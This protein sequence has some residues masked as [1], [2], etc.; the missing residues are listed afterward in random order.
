MPPA[1]AAERS[2]QAALLSKL[3]HEIVIS[4]EFWKHITRLSKNIDDLDKKD[5]N[6]VSRLEKDVEKARKIPSDF[7]ERMAKITTFAYQAW[8]NARAK[9]E[10]KIFAPNLE[11]IIDLEKEYCDY[12]KLPGPS[13]NSLLDDYEEGMTVKKLEQEFSFLESKLVEIL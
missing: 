8:E 6:V 13:Y 4:D 1:G 2:E 12:I 11:K 3:S 7:V 10:F 5:R 9:N